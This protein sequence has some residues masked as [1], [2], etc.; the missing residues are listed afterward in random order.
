MKNNYDVVALSIPRNELGEYKDYIGFLFKNENSVFNVCS[1]EEDIMKSNQWFKNFPLKT[2]VVSDEPIS[3][4]DKF[5]AEARNEELNKKI[6]TYL[7]ETEGGEGLIDIID[8]SGKK[9]V[10]TVNLLQSPKFIRYT[11]A[12]DLKLVVEKQTLNIF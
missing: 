6:F 11:N 12:D 3:I 2:I 7:G 4:G 9:H 1:N 5:L 10:S 8:E